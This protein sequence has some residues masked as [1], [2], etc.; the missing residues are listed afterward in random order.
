M[1]R[2]K[3]TGDDRGFTVIE[4][5]IAFVVLAVLAA[6][7]AIQHNDL[8]SAHRDEQRKTAINAMYYNLTEV[9]Y[10]DH[11]YYP[12]VIS[13]DNLTGIDPAMFTDPDGFILN[14]DNCADVDGN[15]ATGYC[16]YHYESLNCNGNGECQAFKLSADM[17]REATFEKSS[18]KK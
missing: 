1:M 10:K 4:L 16:S 12:R 15:D 9:F 14:G 11:K 6:F 8:L 3:K 18:P 2:M 7:F 5:V 13:R 17:E